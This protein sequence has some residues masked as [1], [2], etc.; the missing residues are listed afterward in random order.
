[1]VGGRAAHVWTECVEA[2]QRVPSCHIKCCLSQWP[3]LRLDR[4]DA[5]PNLAEDGGPRGLV[6]SAHL[7]LNLTVERADRLAKQRDAS[8][9]TLRSKWGDSE[10]GEQETKRR[11]T[12]VAEMGGGG[13]EASG[14]R[15]P[16]RSEDGEQRR[17]PVRM[18]SSGGS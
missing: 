3:Q 12:R 5:L 18:E 17:Q 13:D 15:Q 4:L 7:D 8:A 16:V 11:A 10:M 1:M 9:E 14:L 6:R 2:V